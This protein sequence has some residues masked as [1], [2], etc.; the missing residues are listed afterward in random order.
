M[1]FFKKALPHIVALA[2]FAAVSMIFF[3]PQYQGKALHQS[4]V[5]NYEGMDQDVRQHAGQYKEHPMWL[6]RMFG[7]MPSNTVTMP[8]NGRYIYNSWHNIDIMGS[9]A[10]L[11]FVAMAGFYLML[12][13]FGVNPWIAIAGGLG[14]GLSTYFPII[15]GAGHITKMWALQWVAPM[16]G[17]IWWTYRKNMWAG[18]VLTGIFASLEIGSYHPQIAYYFL[19]V[20]VALAINEFVA[21]FK[22]KTLPKFAKSTALLI[23]AGALAVGSNF[24]Q[25]YFTASYAAEST[26]GASELVNVAGSE[27][28]ANASGGLDKDYI[29]AWS[30]GKAETAN[31]FIPNFAGGGR[32]F[33]QDGELDNTLS[34][35]DVPKDY[36]KNF[37]SYFG[38]QPFTEGPVYIGAVLIFLALFAMFILPSRKKW[39]IA[40]P[41]ILAILLAW[42]KHMMWFTDIFI[43]YFPMYDKFRVVS[44]ILVVVQWAIPALAVLGLYELSKGKVSEARF[45][46]GFKYSTI[47]AA[48]FALVAAIMLPHTMNFVAINDASMGLPE[49]IVGAMQLERADLL[50]TDA[51][52]TLIFVIL[53][54]AA[55]W[56]YYKGKLKTVALAAVVAVLVTVDLWGVDRRYISPDDFVSKTVANKIVANDADKLILADTANFRVADFSVGSPFESSRASYFHRSIGGYSAAKMR[57]YQELIDAHLSKMNVQAYDMLNTKYY[58]SDKGAQLGGNPAG[59]A[60]FADTIVWA[61]NANEELDALS[62]D[63]GFDAHRVAVVDTR[64]KDAVVGVE[65]NVDSAAKVTLTEYRVNR[66]TYRSSAAESGVVVFSEIFADGWSVTIDGEPATPLRANYVLRAVVVPAGDHEIVWSYAP[67]NFKT[68]AAVTTTSSLLLILGA[69]AVLIL[70]F[71]PV[72]KTTKKDG[73]QN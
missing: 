69:L 16:I 58:I 3:Y 56:F 1:Q 67:K 57:R 6:G 19:F 68:V 13:M 40:A 70:Q 37:P 73:K 23:C 52:R 65:P 30:Y 36:Y 10:S 28:E 2:V 20:V 62:V 9:P 48:G 42:G 21:S 31:L 18:A 55:V 38:P 25:L 8:Q 4:D 53:T 12:V 51:W 54:A 72:K 71:I 49:Q 7:G 46:A 24:S 26:R 44:M 29:T 45:S 35:F 61:A 39:W 14:Y 17:A 15:I 50:S 32:D 11:I 41:A 64:F 34:G 22:V 5:T 63:A 66:L 43:D 33:R 60:W 27:Q 47:I 59:N